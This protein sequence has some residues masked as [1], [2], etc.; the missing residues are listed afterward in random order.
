MKNKYI[1]INFKVLVNN[2]D[3]KFGSPFGELCK[4]YFLPTKLACILWCTLKKTK[5]KQTNS[6]K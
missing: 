4:Q 1:S 6:N 3:S 2:Y 5:K